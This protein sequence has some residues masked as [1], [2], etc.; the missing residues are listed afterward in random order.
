MST[1]ITISGS[2]QHGKDTF[3]N[4]AKDYLESVGKKAIVFHYA[5]F[6]K[7]ICK[8]YFNWNG[9]KD[10]AGRTLLQHVGTEMFRTN[11]ATCWIDMARAFVSGLGDSVDYVLIPDARFPN[12][13]SCWNDK[14]CVCIHTNRP[15][16]DNG[17]TEEQKNHS[18]ET[19][20]NHWLFDYEIVNDGSLSDYEQK[21]INIVKDIG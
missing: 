3:A 9:L 17:L 16:F 5:D 18:S 15:N 12:E 7:F 10:E 4:F 14:R 1:I 11:C 20:L 13:I 21:V 2:A 6:L 19:A 8:Q